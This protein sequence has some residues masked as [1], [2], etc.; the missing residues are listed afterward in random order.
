[1]CNVQHDWWIEARFCERKK[2]TIRAIKIKIRRKVR[3]GM[4]AKWMGTRSHRLLHELRN[5]H[6]QSVTK[7]GHGQELRDFISG[8]GGEG[9]CYTLDKLSS[10]RFR[11]LIE[12]LFLLCRESEK[13]RW[14]TT[15]RQKKKN[16]WER[17]EI[18]SIGRFG[19]L[20]IK[21]AKLF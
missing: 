18:R 8:A 11:F 17:C 5:W 16:V 2:T 21:G 7:Y 14:Y 1:M 6:W 4:N 10:G 19:R 3:W 12:R 20:Y 15:C 13:L 9:T